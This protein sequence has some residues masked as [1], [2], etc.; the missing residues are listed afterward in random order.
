MS[1]PTTRMKTDGIECPVAPAS[2]GFW[3]KAGRALSGLYVAT[4]DLD[5]SHRSRS[6]T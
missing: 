2:P 6:L 1:P 5:M 4:W 3:P